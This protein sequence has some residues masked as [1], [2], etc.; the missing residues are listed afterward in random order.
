MILKLWAWMTGGFVVRMLDV[1]GEVTRTVARPHIAGSY[2]AMRMLGTR[3]VL[4]PGG[5]V[6]GAS[7]VRCWWREQ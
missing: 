4:F 5:R 3:V 1:D 7:Y 2:K 6:A